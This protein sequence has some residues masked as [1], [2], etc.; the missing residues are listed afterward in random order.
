MR[1]RY[2]PMM[3]T[4]LLACSFATPH[5]L[6]LAANNAQ[7]L[8]RLPPTVPTLVWN[9]ILNPEDAPLSN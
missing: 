2:R 3:Q 9:C 7:T 8:S 4:D 1:S 5:P 6:D